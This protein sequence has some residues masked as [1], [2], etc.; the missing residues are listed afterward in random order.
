MK[1][2]EKLSNWSQVIPS[3]TDGLTDNEA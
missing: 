3:Q 2:H 1:F